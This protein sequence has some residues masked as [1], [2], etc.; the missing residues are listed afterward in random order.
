MKKG[1]H[2][3]ESIQN[4]TTNPISRAENQ[5]SNKVYYNLAGGCAI[6]ILGILIYYR[7]F[8]CSFH[9]DDFINFVDND[10][11]PDLKDFAAW[12]KFGQSRLVGFYSLAI[13][14]HLNQDVVWGYH[15]VNL[16]IHLI[17]SIL[18]WWLT[19]LMFS[20]DAMK[21]NSLYKFR[22]EIALIT[23][24]LFVSHPL[25]TQSVIYIVQRLTS[26]A[27]LFYLLSIALYVKARLITGPGIL[28]YLLFVAS[29]LSAILAMSTKE[30]AFT[31]PFAIMLFEFFFLYS[32]KPHIKIKSKHIV[33]LLAGLIGFILFLTFKFSLN[34]FK[35]I[36]PNGPH[37]YSLTPMTYLFTQFSV[38]VKY[39]Q[40][41]FVPLNQMVEY[42][43]P[44]S[45][46]FLELK[47]LINFFIL[48]GIFILGIKL[49]NKYRIISFGIF[50][51]FLT[52]SV[53]SSFIPIQDVIFEHRTYL[54]SYG[55]FLIVTLTL[56]VFLREKN[57]IL[58]FFI[59]SII[60]GINS[61]LTFNRIEIWKD[62]LSLWSDNVKKAPKLARPLTNRGFAYRN[63][64]DW[65][66]AL[67]DYNTALK[68][69]PDYVIALNNRGVAYAHF[70]QWDKAI[71]DYNKAIKIDPG[72]TDAYSNRGAAFARMN[73]WNSA[74]SDY[75]KA[76]SINPNYYRAYNNRGM[77]YGMLNEWDKELVDCTKAI[78]IN[79]KFSEAYYNRGCTY[80]SLKEWNKAIEDYSSAISINPKYKEAFVNRGIA[81]SNLEQWS[82]AINDFS[83]ALRIDPNFTIAKNNLEYVNRKIENIQLK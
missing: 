81:F 66:K 49:F 74:I 44:I 60:V 52:L 20:S 42:D 63:L 79:P 13:N 3:K 14:K 77:A 22:R 4:L 58:I 41:L 6:L 80:G 48:A 23:A 64:G 38:I 10:R 56:F 62:E 18:V 68:I 24:L 21:N 83:Q 75:T 28:K 19:L 57:Q 35:P 17:N 45:G 67:A 69:N 51:F 37:T 78:E 2:K 76:I 73:N 26:L 54:P 29:L 8:S 72:N 43:F 70:E 27:A 65:D 40:L 11:L 34:V 50:W 32:M 39:I 71:I 53:E 46:H 9:F 33:L 55:F 12:F 30:N 15:L 47:T 5:D 16:T 1:K 82:K 25:A 7:S 36:P 61:I 59:F 31:L